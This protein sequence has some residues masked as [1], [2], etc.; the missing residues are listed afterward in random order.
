MWKLFLENVLLLRYRDS[1]SCKGNIFE[2]IKIFT[3]PLKPDKG[4]C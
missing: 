3:I 4:D 2:T 1:K